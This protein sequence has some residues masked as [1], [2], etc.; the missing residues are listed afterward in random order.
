MPVIGIRDGFQ[1]LMKGDTGHV[2][3]LTIEKVS[4]IHFRGGS[5]I[6]ISRA[7]PTKDPKLIENTITSLL[8]LNVQR[9]ITIGG[10]DTAFTA[11]K[12]T[13]QSQG[14]IK[15]VHVPKTIDND[16][17]LPGNMPTFGFQ[18]ARH[19]GVSIVKDLQ[20]DAFT[21]STSNPSKRRVSLTLT[22][23]ATATWTWTVRR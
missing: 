5:I 18:T 1:W 20:V 14:R 21:T 12:L 8:R 7:N 19:V 22:L 6:G 23:T 2:T 3:P 16:L 4:R 9:L 13:Q 15:V 11:L 10:D 17:D